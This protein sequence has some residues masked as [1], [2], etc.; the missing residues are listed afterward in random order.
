MRFALP[1]AGTTCDVA[2]LVSKTLVSKTMAAHAE[3]S[4]DGQHIRT[5]GRQCFSRVEMGQ[6]AA[7]RRSPAGLVVVIRLNKRIAVIYKTG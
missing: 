1:A 3:R 7:R 5:T 6:F 4:L 2:V